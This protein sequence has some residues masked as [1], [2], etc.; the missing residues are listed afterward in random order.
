[1]REK[2]PARTLA[3]SSRV[4][5]GKVKRNAVVTGALT[6]H[7]SLISQV[8]FGEITTRH[9]ED[10]GSK[11]LNDAVMLSL[12]PAS[13]DFEWTTHYNLS[14]QVQE[15]A[16]KIDL[17]KDSRIFRDF[18]AEAAKSLNELEGEGERQ[19]L[20]LEDVYHDLYLPCLMK[21]VN[22]YNDLKSGGVTFAEVDVVFKVFV[23][24]YSALTADLQVMCAL[25]SK[26][27]K[28]WIKMRVEQIME[29]HHL[30]QAVRSAEV[31]LKVKE[32]LGLTGDF[33]VLHSLL[34][35]VSY[36]RGMPGMGLGCSDSQE[37]GALA[38]GGRW[39][40]SVAS[41]WDLSFAFHS[42]PECAKGLV[43]TS[44]VGY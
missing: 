32:N 10:L 38:F 39:D 30:H 14:A 27:Q 11:R 16:E 20:Q 7:F 44:A 29:Y 5:A 31:I 13:S 33:S 3:D 2:L 17:L 42:M 1:M 37:P 18:W 8:D 6:A 36:L 22:L 21:F 34:R 23:D 15:M 41:P 26:D 40:A 25:D 24:N 9:S 35:F 4:G 28:D 19:V 12:S 43:I